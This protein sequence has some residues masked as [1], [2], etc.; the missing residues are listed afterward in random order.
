MA[1]A[2]ENRYILDKIPDFYERLKSSYDERFFRQEVLGEYLATDRT[3][4][5]DAFDAKTHVERVDES[6]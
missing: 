4:C 5:I 6:N 2:F 3:G 1:R